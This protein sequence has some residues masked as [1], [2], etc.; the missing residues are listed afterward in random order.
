MESA[1]DGSFSPDSLDGIGV[2]ADDMISDIHASGDYRAHLVR[3]IAKRAVAPAE[4][5]FTE[6]DK[7]RGF[8]ALFCPLSVME[9]ATGFEP[10]TPSL[11]SSCSTN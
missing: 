8:P 4:P 11:G 5:T 3:E 2:D 10:A 1:L 7:G 9:R 6:H